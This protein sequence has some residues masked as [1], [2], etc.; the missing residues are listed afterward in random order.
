MYLQILLFLRPVEIALKKRR[1]SK[2][3][4]QVQPLSLAR[5]NTFLRILNSLMTKSCYDLVADW[6]VLLISVK[7][8]DQ[9]FSQK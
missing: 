7:V 9:V 5:I 8:D 2:S 4:S 1:W 6:T 3:S